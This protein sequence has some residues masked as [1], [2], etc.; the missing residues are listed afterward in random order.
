MPTGGSNVANVSTVT[1]SSAVSGQP[2]FAA[3]DGNIGG[4]PG[5]SSAEWV[6]ADSTV[7]KTML[8]SWGEDTYN[9]TSVVLYDRPNTNGEHHPFPAMTYG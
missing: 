8:M 2:A 7:G 5:N 9:I 3:I 4:Y 6:A 1:A